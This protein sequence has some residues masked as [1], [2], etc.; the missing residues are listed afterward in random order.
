MKFTFL[1]E[2]YHKQ[3]PTSCLANNYFAKE[4]WH[5]IQ[6]FAQVEELA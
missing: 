4:K 6:Q 3:K 2:L 5:Q 1:K